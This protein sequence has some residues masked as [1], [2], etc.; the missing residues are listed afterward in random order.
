MCDVQLMLL[1]LLRSLHRQHSKFQT[2]KT[3]KP[4]RHQSTIGP[5]VIVLFAQGIAWLFVRNR[6]IDP[7]LGS[8]GLNTFCY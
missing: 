8:I 6:D 3:R 1:A 2:R 7:R 5:K 4:I